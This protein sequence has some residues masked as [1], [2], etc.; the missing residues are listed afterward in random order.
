MSAKIIKGFLGNNTGRK[1]V[2]SLWTFISLGFLF[3]NLSIYSLHSIS[4]SE[5]LS[6]FNLFFF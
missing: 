3:V 2:T 1:E 5:M 6:I 4:M